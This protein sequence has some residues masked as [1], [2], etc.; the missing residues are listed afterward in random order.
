M[1]S[2]AS[3]GLTSAS[4]I[5]GEH[6]ARLATDSS[7]G[8]AGAFTFGNAHIAACVAVSFSMIPQVGAVSAWYFGRSGRKEI[9]IRS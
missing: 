2:R 5:L 8:L 9:L 4:G 1:R 6:P 7:D 3:T